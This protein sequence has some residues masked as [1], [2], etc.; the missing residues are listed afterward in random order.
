MIA[1]LVPPAVVL[2]HKAPYLLRTRGDERAEAYLLGVLSSIPLDWYTRRFVEKTMT[3]DIVN[4]L[5]I[6]AASADDPR[7]QRIVEIAGTLAAQDV[8]FA[9]WSEA[10]G[11]EMTDLDEPRKEALA[12]ELDALVC[13]LYELDESDVH[14]IFETFHAGWN[15]QPRLALVLDHFRVIQ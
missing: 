11:V 4:G 12:A 3:F 8:R 15:F 13:S 7:R 1:A 14:L 6:P 9:E 10:V 2:T 5:P